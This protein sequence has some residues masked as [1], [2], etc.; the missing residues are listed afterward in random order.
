M[1][2]RGSKEIKKIKKGREFKIYQKS[3]MDRR[4]ERKKL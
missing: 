4:K 1:R 2:R 3:Q